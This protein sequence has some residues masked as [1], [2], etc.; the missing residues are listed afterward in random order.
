MNNRPPISPPYYLPDGTPLV[1]GAFY[2]T[3]DGRLV[4]CMMDGWLVE[5]DEQ[6][7][8]YRRDAYGAGHRLQ[9][10]ESFVQMQPVA[11]PSTAPIRRVGFE[12][13][14]Q[15]G[16]AGSFAG[17]PP[18]RPPQHY[19]Q[20][21]INPPTSHTLSQYGQPPPYAQYHSFRPA[22][23][24]PQQ[25]PY[26]AS[27]HLPA[28]APP[29]HSIDLLPFQ[30]PLRPPA[31]P[32]ASPALRPWEAVQ[33]EKDKRKLER[34]ER[35]ERADDDWAGKRAELR[36]WIAA[37]KQAEE[38][39]KFLPRTIGLRRSFG[40]V[41]SRES[42]MD[43]PNAVLADGNGDGKGKKRAKSFH[44]EPSQPFVHPSTIPLPPAHPAPPPPPTLPSSHLAL[45]PPQ[46]HFDNP[47]LPPSTLPL[48][49]QPTA[50]ISRP[51][52]RRSRA[53]PQPPQP[54]VRYPS[55]CEIGKALNTAE[56]LAEQERDQRRVAG[57]LMSKTELR[58]RDRQREEYRAGT[59]EREVVR[60]RELQRIKAATLRWE[61][62][63]AKKALR[64]AQREAQKQRKQEKPETKVEK[65][66]R[67]WGTIDEEDS[68]PRPQP[69]PRPLSDPCSSVV[70]AA[71]PSSQRRTATTASSPP[72]QRPL[73]SSTTDL[74]PVFLLPPPGHPDSSSSSTAADIQM[75]ENQPEQ[76]L[77]VDIDLTS[78][79]PLASS[80]SSAPAL[81]I[82]T[83]IPPSYC[84]GGDGADVFEALTRPL[85]A[86]SMADDD[87]LDLLDFAA[88]GVDLSASSSSSLIYSLTGT[89]SALPA[90]QLLLSPLSA[91]T[92]SSLGSSSFSNPS[93]SR[94][95]SLA[96]DFSGLDA[97]ALFP[98]L[99][100]A[101]IS[102]T[103]QPTSFE[104][105]PGLSRSFPPLPSSSAQ[106]S[107]G[108]NADYDLDLLEH[109]FQEKAERLEAE[110]RAR[111]P[112]RPYVPRPVELEESDI[113]PSDS[114]AIEAY[115]REQA[116]R[117]K[118]KHFAI[119][120][121][122]LTGGP[123][124]STSDLPA[125]S[126]F[127]PSPPLPQAMFVPINTTGLFAEELRRQ[128]EQQ[129]QQF[130][131]AQSVAGLVQEQTHAFPTQPQP[132]PVSSSL[133][134]H[135]HFNSNMFP[136]PSTDPLL[137]GFADLRRPSLAD[138]QASRLDNEVGVDPWRAWERQ[139]YEGGGKGKGKG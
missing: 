114:A 58:E 37:K 105:Q 13:S 11:P 118:M 43:E 5:V 26:T 136:T 91:G 40:D 1:S 100:S 63:E 71:G 54:P 45:P 84:L 56:E 38:A 41:E 125:P 128:R 32:T 12:S 129:Q 69:P 98:P 52:I 75:T 99:T 23:L 120:P 10:Y 83:S 119:Y 2:R 123:H 3:R 42:D 132:Q 61:R 112:G 77:S 137:T 74:G 51:V 131:F 18:P 134:S 138:S 4:R 117:R 81:S 15:V 130:D 70:P 103:T 86:A 19:P 7:D 31:Q 88:L 133:P 9:V 93:D 116:R 113:N 127:P 67:N 34:K 53:K 6:R 87:L 115:R 8:D 65:L 14:A 36:T 55:A 126:F 64:A 47:S 102:A 110:H 79:P 68:T 44:D 17:A 104:P 106:H 78:S 46:P 39:E 35:N 50:V 121:S 85:H 22:A 20:H 27:I 101:D 33:E 80:S 59:E 57:G 21:Y 107:G 139:E 73:S 122:Q 16:S 109:L 28:S 111:F 94:R 97:L 76:T 95:G 29:Y 62:E 49:V 89:S 96:N 92:Q 60:A 82:D 30:S 48:S 66:R 25:P 72:S 124:P 135:P 108:S 24:P 90:D